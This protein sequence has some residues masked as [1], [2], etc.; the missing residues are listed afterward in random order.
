[1]SD[2]NI[3]ELDIELITEAPGD[4]EGGETVDLSAPDNAGG[5]DQANADDNTNAEDNNQDD[6]A[7][8]NDDQN[9]NN[10][11]NNDNNQTDQE[12]DDNFDIDDADD[13]DNNDT[14][15]DTND[16]ADAEDNQAEEPEETDKEKEENRELDAIYD[17]LTPA[18]KSIRDQLLR[19][20]FKDLYFAIDQLINNTE[21]FPKMSDSI[22]L[23][24][25]LIINLNDFKEYVGYYFTQTYDTKSHMENL[26]RYRQFVQIFV[27]IESIYT[28][29]AGAM[30]H[31]YD[32]YGRNIEELNA[33]NSIED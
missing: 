32:K 29:L 33:M 28:D 3:E 12:T 10:D 8:T 19:K 20:Q 9:D 11:Q 23:I 4:E 1:M 2:I 13:T 26:T 22:K 15:N 24:N 6:N 21:N 7:D 18:E 17:Q 25:R 31:E 14:N 16:Q 27:A 5:D 30:G